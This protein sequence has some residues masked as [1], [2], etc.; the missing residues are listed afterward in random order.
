MKKKSDKKYMNWFPILGALILGLVLGAVLY[1]VA[2][3]EEVDIETCSDL[4][5]EEVFEGQEFECNVVESAEESNS[6]AAQAP[7]VKVGKRCKLH[8]SKGVRLTCSF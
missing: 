7:S 3:T 4:L 1:S 8:I 5:A 6:T 2:D